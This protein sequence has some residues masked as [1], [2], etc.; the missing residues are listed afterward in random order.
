MH[1]DYDREKLRQLYDRYKN[2]MY[3]TACKVLNDPQKAEDAVHD[4]FIAVLKHLDKIG[5][6]DSVS[7]AAY[8]IKA[9]RSRALN[10]LRMGLPEKETALDEAM[11]QRDESILD[12]ICRK[13]SYQEIVSAI[14]LLESR[15]RDVLTFYYLNDLSVS[16]IA[17]LTAAKEN[18]VKQQLFRGRQKLIAI[19]KKEDKKD[20]KEQRHA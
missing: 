7:T 19:L 8:M 1:G 11:A 17:A 5:D 18:T 6:V 15:Y 10:I 4:A 3:I 12:E 2:R 9:A 16:E 13:E 14:L 20:E